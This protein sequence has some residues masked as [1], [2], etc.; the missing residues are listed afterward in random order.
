MGRFL[1]V[2]DRRPI[3]GGQHNSGWEP[4]LNHLYV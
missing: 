1:A 3:T 4:N 2:L